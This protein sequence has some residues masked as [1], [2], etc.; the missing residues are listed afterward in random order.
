VLGR[1]EG[2]VLGRAYQRQGRPKEA[3]M[4]H[5]PAEAVQEGGQASLL[6]IS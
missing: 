1:A 4:L 5:R 3:R 6:V 2:K